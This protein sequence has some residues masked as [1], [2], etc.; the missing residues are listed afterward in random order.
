MPINKSAIMKQKI[1]IIMLCIS[2]LPVYLDAQKISYEISTGLSLAS[3]SKDKEDQECSPTRAGFISGLAFNIKTGKHWA[4]Q[5]GINYVQK[6]GSEQDSTS[7]TKYSTTLNYLELPVNIRYSQRE[8]CFFGFGLFVS[9][10][11]SGNIK[12]RDGDAAGEVKVKFGDA[13]DEL[14]PVE[15]GINIFMGYRLPSNIFFAFNINGSFNN[16]SNMPGGYFCNSYM[17]LRVGYVF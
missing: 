13:E 15:T 14:K 9:Y 7:P 16:I 11:L 10:G 12:A 17:G 6:G 1:L 4:I 2:G 3:Y 5:P 8:R